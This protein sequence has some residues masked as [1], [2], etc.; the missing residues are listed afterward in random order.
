MESISI[1]KLF[2]IRT[3]RFGKRG[4][5]HMPVQWLGLDVSTMMSSIQEHRELG[6]V[7]RSCSGTN[8]GTSLQTPRDKI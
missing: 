3:G 2:F 7:L 5:E 6:A 8:F 4:A 1:C